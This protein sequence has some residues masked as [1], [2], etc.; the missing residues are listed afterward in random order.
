MART[1][2]TSYDQ[3]AVVYHHRNWTR[4]VGSRRSPPCEQPDSG[5]RHRLVQAAGRFG[6]MSADPGA[7]ARATPMATRPRRPATLRSSK[8]PTTRWSRSSWRQSPGRPPRRDG[9][10]RIERTRRRGAAYALVSGSTPV[11]DTEYYVGLVWVAAAT[12]TYT[13]RNVVI[14]VEFT[15]T[16]D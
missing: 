13:A 7:S 8:S 3:P 11:A 16:D 5:G 2:A 6:R 4:R 12:N 1:N 10:R 9:R 14:E 15:G